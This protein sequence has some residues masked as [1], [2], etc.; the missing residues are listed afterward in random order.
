[1]AYNADNRYYWI[2]A[3][4]GEIG[5]DKN[6]KLFNVSLQLIEASKKEPDSLVKPSWNSKHD[7]ILMQKP[8]MNEMGGICL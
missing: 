4:V 6:L 7:I 2:N 3:L 1:M 5:E 8:V